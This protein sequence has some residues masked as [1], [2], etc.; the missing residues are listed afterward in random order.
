LLFTSVVGEMVFYAIV[1]GREQK[2]APYDAELAQL[3]AS[4]VGTCPS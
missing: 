4:T 1:I 2:T 3:L